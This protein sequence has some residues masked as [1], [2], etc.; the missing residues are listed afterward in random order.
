[1]LLKDKCIKL[2]L[3]AS[4]SF[5]SFMMVMI[6]LPSVLY[7]ETSCNCVAFTLDGVQDYFLTNVQ[8]DIIRMF[9]DKEANLTIGIIGNDFGLDTNITSF[10]QDEIAVGPKKSIIEVAN[11]GWKGEDYVTLTKEQ[12]SDLIGRTQARVDYLLK[13]QPLTF[14]APFGNM[15]NDTI[16]SL[17]GGNLKYAIGYW[18][19]DVPIRLNE[20]DLYVIPPGISTGKLKAGSDLYEATP[21]DEL[22]Q[23]IQ[24]N[25]T[26]NGVAVV[27]MQPLEFARKNQTDYINQSD[28]E[29]ITNLG[30]LL[31]TLK[32]KNVPIVTI[33]ALS[34]TI[35]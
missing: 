14:L 10:I 34:K 9:D 1:M 25:I 18:N 7:A 29:Q 24:Q 33:T 32:S 30:S 4:I 2:I 19:T 35:N 16:E 13:T 20:S 6:S 31:D 26:D 27:S 21:Y 11:N 28:Q 17:R 22:V 12:Q 23:G 15:N 8:M 3:L 5:I